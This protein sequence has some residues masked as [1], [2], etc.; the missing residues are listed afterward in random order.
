[1]LARAAATWH[2]G[3]IEW[4]LQALQHNKVKHSMQMHLCLATADCQDCGGM[5]GHVSR[6]I[7]LHVSSGHSLPGGLDLLI[8]TQE[9]AD[10]LLLMPVLLLP[11]LQHTVFMPCS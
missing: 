10:L 11:H 4:H 6:V 7:Y 1:M 8:G 3:C 9:A 5:P 2:Y